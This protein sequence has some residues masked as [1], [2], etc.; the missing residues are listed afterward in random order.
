VGVG[1][2]KKKILNGKT[3]L[4]GR[5]VQRGEAKTNKK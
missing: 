5:R 1:E 2:A 4:D 3:H